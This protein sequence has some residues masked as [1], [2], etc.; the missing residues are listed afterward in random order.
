MD[1]QDKSESQRQKLR[2]KW[3]TFHVATNREKRD[4]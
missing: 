1:P 2:Q 4:T 3:Q